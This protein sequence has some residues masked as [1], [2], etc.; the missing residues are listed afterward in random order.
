MKII[1]TD[2]NPSPPH[3]CRLLFFPSSLTILVFS[4]ISASRTRKY[5]M[6]LRTYDD[7]VL[8]LIPLHAAPEECMKT[9]MRKFSPSTVLLLVLVGCKILLFRTSQLEL[10]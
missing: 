7:N 5:T 6:L 8:M 9:T 1:K 2:G 4:C 10:V 3:S